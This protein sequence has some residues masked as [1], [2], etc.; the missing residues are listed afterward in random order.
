MAN[1]QRPGTKI[2]RF[3]WVQ[4]GIIQLH[5]NRIVAATSRLSMPIP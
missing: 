1:K 3:K 2:F 5:A 4:V